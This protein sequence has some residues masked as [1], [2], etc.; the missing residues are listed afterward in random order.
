MDESTKGSGSLLR[1]LWEHLSFGLQE[2]SVVSFS[3]FG[4]LGFTGIQEVSIWSLGVMRSL[5]I[6]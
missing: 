3:A 4:T 6:G 1:Y 2:L 5:G